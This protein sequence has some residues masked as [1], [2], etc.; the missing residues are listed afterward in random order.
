VGQAVSYLGDYMAYISIPLFVAFIARE[1][2]SLEFGITYALDSAPTLI[3]G[4]VG[5]ILLDR[6]RLRPVMIVADLGRAAAF[7]YL[8]WVANGD[9]QPGSGQGIGVVFAVAFVVGSFTSLFQSGLFT[10]IPAL[11]PH[12][13]LAV[14]NG[15][16]TAAQ[17]LSVALGPFIA[18]VL[19]SASDSFSLVFAVD[20]A[21]FLVSALSLVLI[22]P[23]DRQADPDP[24]G[25]RR[26]LTEGLRYLWREARLRVSTIALAA[27]NFVFGFLEATF[28][29]AAA[30]PDLVG[31]AE[32]WKQGVL[33]AMFGL[34]GVAGSVVAPVVARHIGLGRT[35][36][37]GFAVFGLAY[38]VFVNT[39]FGP[40]GL[41]YLF[42]ALAGLQFVNVPA[43]TIRQIYSPPKLL[44]RVTAAS[45]ALAWSSL[46]VG[47]LVGTAVVD[48]VGEVAEGLSSFVVAVRTAPM[49]ILGIG[50]ALVP[51]VIW[52]DTF[53][54]ERGRRR[55]T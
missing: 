36:V 30:D 22:G 35:M 9:I 1:G 41:L 8:A 42:L 20:A 52:R 10:L 5:G 13:E 49:V 12:R 33:F 55:A 15:R 37:L 47:A 43:A 2:R 29:L 48:A 17:N 44:G 7:A 19:I 32:G 23:V 18:G 53:G 40:V 28:V 21:T 25:I 50:L 26:E 14:A 24:A 39:P 46:P 16:V 3:L 51:T 38:T 11:V 34:G 27:G 45:R 31:A 6:L 54:S 4:L